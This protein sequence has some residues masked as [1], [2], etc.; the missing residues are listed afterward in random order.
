MIILGGT[1]IQSN[2]LVC[3]YDV[4]SQLLD[5][6]RYYEDRYDMAEDVSEKIAIREEGRRKLKE[7]CPQLYDNCYIVS[8]ANA[9]ILR[10]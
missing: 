4:F 3:D 10:V 9:I 1:G 8:K 2:P 6:L 7:F 5:I